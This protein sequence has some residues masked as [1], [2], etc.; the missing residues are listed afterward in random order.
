MTGIDPQYVVSVLAW[1]AVWSVAGLTA[2]QLLARHEA[3]R[4]ARRKPETKR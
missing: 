2:R 3:S 4:P 1:A